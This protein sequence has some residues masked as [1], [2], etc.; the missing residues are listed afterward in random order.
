M[1]KL[2]FVAII[3]SLFFAGCG[4]DETANKGKHWIVVDKQG[5]TLITVGKYPDFVISKTIDGSIFVYEFS[6][7]FAISPELLKSC[8]PLSTEIQV[9]STTFM[10]Y[11]VGD[12]YN[13]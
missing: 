9:D 4:I 13:R 8:I 12:V 11:S 10:A 6:D 1:K 5:V 3:S 2:I 7:D